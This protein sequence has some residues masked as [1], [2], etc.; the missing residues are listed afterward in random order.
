MSLGG[1]FSSAINSAVKATYNKGVVVV[2]AAGNDNAD[3]SNYSPA[4]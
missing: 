3:A 2:V 4:S 1:G